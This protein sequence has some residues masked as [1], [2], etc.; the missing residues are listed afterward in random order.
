[1]YEIKNKKAKIVVSKA[2]DLAFEKS[3]KVLETREGKKGFL[4]WLKF[5]NGTL[6]T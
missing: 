1:M 6:E 4:G 5:R 3:Y 2:K